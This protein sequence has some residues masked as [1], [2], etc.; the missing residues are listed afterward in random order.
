M[1]HVDAH[2]MFE[3]DFIRC[4][5][6][7]EEGAVTNLGGALVVLERKAR[8]DQDRSSLAPFPPVDSCTFIGIWTGVKGLRMGVLRHY[9]V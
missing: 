2:G 8:S 4:L 1:R 3:I 9:L 5:K 6:P 7:K